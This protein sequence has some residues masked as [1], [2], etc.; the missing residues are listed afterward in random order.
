MK[1]E[2][3]VKLKTYFKKK[4]DKFDKIGYLG[5][6]YKLMQQHLDKI[7]RLIEE[8]ERLVMEMDDDNVKK[9]LKI[10]H[11][12]YDKFSKNGKLKQIEKLREDVNDMLDNLRTPDGRTL[13]EIYN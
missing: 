7:N 6:M 1:R 11:S 8:N 9:K 3:M 10:K 5:D 2:N 13:K 4:E 12:I